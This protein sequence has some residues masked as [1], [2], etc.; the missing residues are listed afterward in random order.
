M[1]LVQEEISRLRDAVEAS[2]KRKTRKRRYIRAEETLTV[3]EVAD[4]I[5]EKEG[6]GRSEGETPAKRVRVGRRCGRCSEIGH[7]SR[8][9]KVEIEDA[10]DSEASE[11]YY[12]GLQAII[13][14]VLCCNTALRR[15]SAVES[16]PLGGVRR[17]VV[18]HVNYCKQ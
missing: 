16:A 14:L 17:S 5:A 15:R 1:V 7:N 8:T 18:K 12:L 3:G 13:Y 11:Q 4:L 10:D 6:G 9:C 2:T